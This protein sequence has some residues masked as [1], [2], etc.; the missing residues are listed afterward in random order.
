MHRVGRGEECAVSGLVNKRLANF[1]DAEHASTVR[2][3]FG[4]THES[5]LSHDL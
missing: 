5:S 2:Y 1:D 3:R 4:V